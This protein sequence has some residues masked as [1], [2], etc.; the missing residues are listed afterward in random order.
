MTI[1]P[2]IDP[3]EYGHLKQLAPDLYWARFALPFR[4]NHIN[5][6]I[7]D[8]PEGWVLID[9]GINSDETHDQWTALLEGPLAH[10]R[11][12][13][14]I[15]THHHVD[16]IG[17]ASRLASRTKAPVIM[18]AGEYEK[19]QWLI[20]QDDDVFANLV[21]S[22]YRRY[23]LGD[24][25]CR[26]VRADKGRFRRHVAPLPDVMIC[27]TGQHIKSREGCFEI[28]IDEGH[29]H[30]HIGL[31]DKA[32]QLYI[33][34]D[35]LLPRISPNI[36]VD[37]RDLT[38]DMLGAYLGYLADISQLDDSWHILPGHDWPFFG[39]GKRA[40][41]LLRHHQD[42][43]DALCH[44]AEKKPLSVDDAMGVLFGKSF[45]AHELYFASGEARAHLTHLL[46]KGMIIRLPASGDNQPDYFV[47]SQP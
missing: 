30:A 24:E 2:R 15:I 13:R 33:A 12:A 34:M 44:A 40:Q 27:T 26:L 32:R 5:L 47:L 23:G 4:L 42:R 10:Q 14:I 21:E 28:R 25:N 17:Y 46:A 1:T 41:A 20:E 22:T 29:S 31:M 6:Y 39:G 8:T 7:I 38:K 3:P 36:S 9:A 37:L 16:H 18:S 45:A 35:F 11:V 19:A 43:L